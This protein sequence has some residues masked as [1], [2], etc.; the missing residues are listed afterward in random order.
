M[1]FK[2]GAVWWA[3]V[4]AGV[5]AACSDGDGDDRAKTGAIY[6]L[7][8]AVFGADGDTTTYVSI[9]DTLDPQTIDYA[10]AIELPGW[11]DL[12]VHDGHVF[13]SG[14]ESPTVTKYSV[15]D[16]G[17][18]VEEATISFQSYGLA[19]TAFWDNTFVTPDK[20]YMI[21]GTTGYVVWNPSTM[22]IG[23]TIALP[24]LEA[25]EGLV[26]RA[27]TL[28]RANVIRDGK[29]FQPMYWSDADYARF[30]PESRIVV[31]DIATDT[32]ETVLSAPCAGADVGTIDA[33]GN[34]YF[35][36]WTGG[37]YAP[38]VIPDTPPNCVIKVPA[39]ETTAAVAFTFPD[40][41]D[42]REGAAVKHL[43]DG[44]L[45]FSVFHDERV[46]LVNAE[47]PFKLIGEKNWRLWSYDPTSGSA[48]PMESVDWN[49]GAVYTFDVDDSLHALIPGTDYASTTLYDL[50]D[51]SAATPLF[52][53]RGWAIR[54]FHI[55]GEDQP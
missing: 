11:A 37:I 27:G 24:A 31:I 42:G 49:S 19:S 38:L 18:L 20:A 14:G 43:G 52:D 22:E 1:S 36:T 16:R 30:A 51:G 55:R 39:G 15:D 46:D 8:S 53:T 34:L 47:D 6:A 23:G 40:V 10:D 4:A 45:L 2:I 7:A 29:L 48:A 28:D 13:V 17:R 50:G 25:R 33:A 21:N 41:T 9:L 12:W 35:S 3:T 54:L 32:V 5:L 26:P 44:K